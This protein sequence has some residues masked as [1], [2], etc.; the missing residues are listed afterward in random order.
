MAVVKPS[1]ARSTAKNIRGSALVATEESRREVPA[2]GKPRET[3]EKLV[4]AAGKLLGEVGFE[5]L[6]TNAIC[7]RARMTPPAFYRYFTDKY[8]ILEVLARRLL[9]RQNDAYAVWLYNSPSDA[10]ILGFVNPSVGTNGRL[11]TAGGFPTNASH[12]HQL[13]ITLE[14]QSNPKTPGTI[15]L[16]GAGV[17]FDVG[18]S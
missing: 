12:F 13:L 1:K 5:K 10:R 2:S 11:Q 16:R 7:A 8:E 6:T 3:Y 17:Q 15:V 9:K 18:Q 4:A 14:T